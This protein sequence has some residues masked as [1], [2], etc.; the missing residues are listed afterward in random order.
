MK[1]QQG[2]TYVSREGGDAEC[3]QSRTKD[4]G[5]ERVGDMS[6][7]SIFIQMKQCESGRIKIEIKQELL[8]LCCPAGAIV[9]T[10]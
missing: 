9:G 3:K 4:A 6:L 1:W 5:K 2:K 8:S 7:Y 10:V